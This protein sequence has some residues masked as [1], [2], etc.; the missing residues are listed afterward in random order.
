MNKLVIII[1]LATGISV[2]VNAKK[3]NLRLK[4]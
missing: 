3:N 2:N 1:L 4:I